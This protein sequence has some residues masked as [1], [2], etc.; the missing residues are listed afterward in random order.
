[1][2]FVTIGAAR[3]FPRLIS[4]MDEIAGKTDE[5]VIIQVGYTN[6]QPI[7][8]KYLTFINREEMLRLI[9]ES[10]I[11]VTHSGTSITDI[12][13]LG[14]PAVVVPRFK[15]YHEAI[16]DHQVELCQALEKQ[17]KIIAIYDIEKLE[18]A[19]NEPRVAEPLV[20]N[21]CRLI[22]ALRKYID[23]FEAIAKKKAG[24]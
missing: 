19:L 24:V 7:H 15:K 18:A 8:A 16:N 22:G 9:Q 21:D 14:R 2:I 17:G 1:M 23:E 6:Y 13:K 12:L 4:K 11:V 20:R 10:R 3:G 5:E